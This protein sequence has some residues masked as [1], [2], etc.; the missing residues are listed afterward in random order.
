MMTVTSDLSSV[1]HNALRTNQ[2]L[3]ITLLIV[4][5]VARAPVLALLVGL[6]MAI[7][8]LVGAPGFKPVYKYMVKPLGIKP[9][10]IQ[11]NPKPHRFS[12]PICLGLCI[13]VRTT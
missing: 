5:F 7:G 9:D 1:D 4:A 10:V 8:S 6:V 2:A 11:D 13:I 12:L 3:I